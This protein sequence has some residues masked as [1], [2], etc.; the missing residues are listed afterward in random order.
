MARL[1]RDRDQDAR[2]S[3]HTG[4]RR[5]CPRHQTWDFDCSTC[6]SIAESRLTKYRNDETRELVATRNTSRFGKE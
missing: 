3:P 5:E 1:I 4:G 6:V 2:P